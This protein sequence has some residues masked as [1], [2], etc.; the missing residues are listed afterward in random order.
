MS[1]REAITKVTAGQPLGLSDLV[2]AVQ[3]IGYKFESKN[4]RNSVG[5]Y[6]YSPHGKKY[7]KRVNGKFSPLK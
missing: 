2:A 3:R 6:L 5:A 4:P 7:F 1:I